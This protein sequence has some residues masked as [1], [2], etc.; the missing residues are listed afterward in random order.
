M[1][2]SPPTVVQK[3]GK[4]YKLAPDFFTIRKALY[5][6]AKEEKLL[7]LICISLCK[8]VGEKTNG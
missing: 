7:S 1:L 2:I 3:Q 8:I 4:N 6:V 5:E